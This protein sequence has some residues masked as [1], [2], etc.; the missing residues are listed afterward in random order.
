MLE[1]K[2]KSLRNEVDAHEP[3]IISVVDLGLS[4]IEQGHPQADEFQGHINDLNARWDELQ[5]AIDERKDKLDQS[6]AAQQVSGRGLRTSL[7]NHMQ[8]SRSVGGA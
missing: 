8:R 7:T 2:N 5:R 4:L 3:R 1:K 6:R